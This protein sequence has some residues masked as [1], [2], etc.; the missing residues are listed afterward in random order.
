MGDGACLA[1]PRARRAGRGDTMT[2]AQRARVKALFA[3]VIELPAGERAEFLA[4]EAADDADVKAEVKSLLD[5]H[6]QP[7]AFLE[8]VSDELRATAFAASSA[9]R[10]RLGERIGA[11]RVIGILGSGGMGDVFKAVRDDD[12]YH[13]EVAIKL[14]RADMRSVL[15]D[16]RFKNERQILAGL[17]HRNI[18]RLLDG[19]TTQGGTPY[20]VMELVTGEPIDRYCDERKLDVRERVSLF[21]QVCAAVS[22]AHQHLVV[23][24]DLKPNNILVTAD[25]SVKLLDFGIAKLLEPNADTFS[26]PTEQTAT[27]LRAMTLDFASPEQ[28]AGGI[29]TTVS[30]VYSLGVVLYR[31]LTGKSPYGVRAN[32]A[33]RMAEILSDTTPTRPSQVERRIDGDLDNILLMALRK[34]PQ[35]RYGSVEQ[36]GNDLRNFLGGMP[37]R[38]RGNSLRYRFGKFARR[39]RWEIAAGVLVACALLTAL[40]V[41][42]RE[43]RIADRE[44]QVAQQHFASVRKL[45][46]TLLFEIHDEIAKVPGSTKSRELLVKTSLEYLDALYKGAGT[47]RALQ[48]ELAAA[49][50]KVGNIQGDEGGSNIGAYQDALKSYA[51][52]I[53]LFESLVAQ[54]P[55]NHRA[56]LNLGRAYVKQGSLM[57]AVGRIEEA[58]VSVRKG[59]ALGESLKAFFPTSAERASQLGNTYWTQADIY[60]RLGRSPE[61]MGSIDK[62][63][64]V[65]EDFWRENPKDEDALVSLSAAYNNAS[66]HSDSR[67]PERERYERTLFMLRRSLW[68]DAQL[69]ALAPDDTEHL[70]N[71][72]LAQ[73]NL[74]RLLAAHGDFAAALES[75]RPATA[76]LTERA[77]DPNDARSHYLSAMMDSGLAEALFKVGKVED[78][79]AILVRCDQVFKGLLA[80]GG[81]LRIDFA[82]GQNA[83]RLGELYVT[84]ALHAPGASALSYW[85]Q[86]QRVLAPGVAAL[87]KV[88]AAVALEPMDKAVIDAGVAALARAEAATAGR[89]N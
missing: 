75:Y 10:S 44:R 43:G 65:V 3:A 84:H 72:A 89:L 50:L 85:Q 45:A 31:L 57:L 71:L 9:A 52:S 18:A 17:D 73:F 2:P 1:A 19:G 81:T 8:T 40:G 78:A 60:A 22:Y 28:V 20:V 42:I 6:E 83:V 63:L 61:A 11:Y 41:S 79:K 88:A 13:A 23:H 48:E 64:E 70:F 16:L 76:V 46:S 4:R 56:G 35:R 29:V 53:A 77:K 58:L 87:Q 86:A 59:V 5:A 49:Y 69:V 38:A 82:Y 32:D 47:D 67:L 34:D 21:L 39:R 7:G 55:E 54:S 51:R 66:I 33:Q 37:V 30:D 24:R 68:A 62:L 27:T 36:L 26:A 80:G 25:G 14:M 15:T 74:G 12:Q